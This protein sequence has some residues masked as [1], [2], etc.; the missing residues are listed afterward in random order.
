MEISGTL[1]GR[2][3]PVLSPARIY[4]SSGLWEQRSSRGTSPISFTE[5]ALLSGAPAAEEDLLPL[6]VPAAERQSELLRQQHDPIVASLRSQIGEYFGHYLEPPGEASPMRGASSLPYG[7][8]NDDTRAGDSK[9]EELLSPHH[10]MASPTPPPPPAAPEVAAPAHVPEPALPSGD[11]K[12]M[13][14]E[15]RGYAS[16][17]RVSQLSTEADGSSRIVIP[18]T[19]SSSRVSHVHISP[20]GDISISLRDGTALVGEEL[21]PDPVQGPGLDADLISKS[22]PGLA[23]ATETSRI[24][25][26]SSHQPTA[27]PADGI[28]MLESL[29]STKL[30]P[31]KL[32]AVESSPSRRSGRRSSSPRRR[33]ADNLRHSLSYLGHPEEAK[34]FAA[35]ETLT[36]D[37]ANLSRAE[38]AKLA[39][40]EAFGAPIVSMLQQPPLEGSDLGEADMARCHRLAAGILGTVGCP[41]L[42]PLI[43]EII[44]RVWDARDRVRE[45]TGRD[46]ESDRAWVAVEPFWM[47][48]AVL[49]NG[50][51]LVRGMEALLCLCTDGL[52]E[53][54]GAVMHAFLRRPVIRRFALVP[55]I[56]RD[57]QHADASR[58][59]IAIDVLAAISDGGVVELSDLLLSGLE[60]S[61][62]VCRAIRCL[63]QAGE[64][65]LAD[66]CVNNE[67]DSARRDAA[68]AL[69]TPRPVKP[70]RP[71]IRIRSDINS[72][73]DNHPPVTIDDWEGSGENV[74]VTAFSVDSRELLNSVKRMM[75]KE[76]MAGDDVFGGD[77]RISGPQQPSAGQVRGQIV[78]LSERNANKICVG[79]NDSVAS[80]RAACARALGGSSGG[81]AVARSVGGVAKV[82]K[83]LQDADDG[84]RAAAVSALGSFG[85]PALAEPL[86]VSSIKKAK[87]R[88]RASHTPRFSTSK[89]K[90]RFFSSGS[91]TPSSA[92][93]RMSA[94]NGDGNGDDPMLGDDTLSQE[95]VMLRTVT[96]MLKDRSHR[97]R[98]AACGALGRFGA[99]A[100]SVSSQVAEAL[101]R[102][103][104]ERRMAAQSLA[105]LG[106]EGQRRLLDMVEKKWDMQSCVAA[107]R[108]IG[109][110]PV[111]SPLLD[112]IIHTLF[113][114]CGDSLPSLRIAAIRALGQLGLSAGDSATFL[115]SRSLLPFLYS[116]MRDSKKDVRL[117]AASTLALSTQGEMLLVEGLLQDKLPTVRVAAATGLRRV[118]AQ[119]IRT[120]LLALQD[121]N[122]A[123]R[124]AAGRAILGIG[125]DSIVREMSGRPQ[126]QQ[127][128]FI[129]S[130]KQL[131]ASGRTQSDGVKYALLQVISQIES[132]TTAHDAE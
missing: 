61:A 54:Q 1:S 9:E 68:A 107:T 72:I 43:T 55:L 37:V 122:V 100:A 111:D 77:G 19:S 109:Y 46:T 128:A 7:G 57:L 83:L 78:H 124:D 92:R 4:G 52:G 11:A 70:Q 30:S 67:R 110:A 36:K 95:G 17:L 21:F 2:I 87:R 120:L 115:Q 85:G 62:K 86:D 99:H 35:L 28:D 114:I 26:A 50:G 25:L 81:L 40:N 16:P 98:A 79:L 129:L 101:K 27:A 131:L 112:E 58:R 12:I 31:E 6:Q 69:A 48:D 104:V 41:K 108:G 106:V 88:L 123:V 90:S 130:A 80:V 127:A 39:E 132:E 93:K 103:R 65:L 118:G 22:Q 84:V 94:R 18:Q 113:Q 32:A 64:D 3:S 8:S 59:A 15:G 63:G 96:A 75:L 49:S 117:A 13:Q 47:L 56:A 102:G 119:S 73:I 20:Q 45:S 76:G 126:T 51:D 71:R 34:R 66:V 116:H 89:R 42:L 74:R 23:A 24:A 105:K 33:V 121:S 29:Y 38:L 60:E 53:R 10:L 125:V 44:V 97:V 82:F 91:S 5:Q 14:K